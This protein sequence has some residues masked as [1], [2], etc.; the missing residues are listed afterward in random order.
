M[1]KVPSLA[2]RNLGKSFGATVALDGVSLDVYPGEVHGVLGQ[3]GAGKSTLVK[4]LTG[5]YPAGSF[6]GEFSVSGIPAK[7]STPH[8]ARG[9]RVG[10]VPQEIEVVDELDVTENVLA[11]RVSSGLVFSRR[12]ARQQSMRLMG[13]LGLSIDVRRRVGGLSA[14]QRQMVMIA[15]A[16]ANEPH[17]LILDEPTTSLSEVE[18]H[19]LCQVVKGLADEGLSIV[20][21]THR[22]REVM[23]ICDNATVLRDGRVAESLPRTDFSEHRIV[24]GMAGREIQQLYPGRSFSTSEVIL[25]CEGVSTRPASAGGSAISD[26]SLRLHRGEILGIAGVLGSGRTELLQALFGQSPR[27][28]EVT[29]A[30]QRVRPGDPGSAR[31][32]GIALL[33]E[34][35]KSQG[36]LFN[37]PVA[38]NATLGSLPLVSRFGVIGRK[39]E[40]AVARNV[41]DRFSVKVPSITASVTHLSGGNQQKLLLGRCLLAQPRVVLLDEPTKG[42]DVG[43]RQQIYQHVADLSERGTGVI[44]VSSELDELLGM[45]DRVIVL[46]SGRVVDEFRRG[47]GD[48]IRILE[49]VALAGVSVAGEAEK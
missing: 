45:S 8:D 14:A 30:D 25:S 27:T 19:R 43:T 1:A 31:R 40:R 49:A 32:A 5:V 38:Q 20:F 18:A 34:D 3:N 24:S 37:L 28:G 39:A 47:E 4:I 23:D 48:E 46:G 17:V 16:L 15:R 42:V 21:I 22:V 35:R 29:V 11:G 2:I 7:F 33:T 13:K 26:V 10:Y 44:V 12:S 9:A 41:A 36:L 6:A